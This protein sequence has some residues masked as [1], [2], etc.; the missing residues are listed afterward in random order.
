MKQIFRYISALA[1]FFISFAACQKDDVSSIVGE[2]KVVSMT[3]T[4]TT[5][6]TENTGDVSQFAGV[7]AVGESLELYKD[8]IVPCPSP[9]QMIMS[10]GF[11]ALPMTV[12]CTLT[13]STLYI[14]QQV[15]TEERGEGLEKTTSCTMFSEVNLS[16]TNRGD[17]LSLYDKFESTDKLGYVQKRTETTIILKRP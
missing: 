17:E 4:I 3:Q 16:I 12:P 10:G 2:W 7:F 1:L 13:S 6:S 14:P 15:Y 5:S 11:V 9:R 8:H